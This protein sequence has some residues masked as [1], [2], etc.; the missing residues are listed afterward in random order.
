MENLLDLVRDFGFVLACCKERTPGQA[1]WGDLL[2]L[3]RA[4]L[5]V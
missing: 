1:L 2:H 4:L 5:D 3:T